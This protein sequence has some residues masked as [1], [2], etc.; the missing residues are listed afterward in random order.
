[1]SS[2]LPAMLNDGRLMADGQNVIF[3]I[4]IV[5]FECKS[6][7]NNLNMCAFNW[8]IGRFQF[9]YWYN[10]I[11]WFS[12]WNDF[13]TAIWVTRWSISISRGQTNEPFHTFWCLGGFLLLFSS[14]DSQCSFQIHFSFQFHFWR[15]LVNNTIIHLNFNLF[16]IHTPFYQQA[17][18]SAV[19]IQHI[20]SNTIV[21]RN[22]IEWKCK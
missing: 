11:A 9:K 6:N 20:E 17:A 4:C 1:M 14:L 3:I 22:R 19:S 5:C 2:R 7:T 16:S 8:S 10:E 18:S 15:T 12:I 21:L 13:D